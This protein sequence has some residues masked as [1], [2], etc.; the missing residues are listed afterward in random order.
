MAAIVSPARVSAKHQSLLHLIGEA[1]R[2]GEAVLGKVAVLAQLAGLAARGPLLA[3]FEEVH[4]IDSTS[5]P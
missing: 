5:L 2:S 1:P 4:W 3:I